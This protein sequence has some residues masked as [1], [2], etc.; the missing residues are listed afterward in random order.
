MWIR[1]H[2]ANGTQETSEPALARSLRA[3]VR[4]LAH[5]R[6]F[7]AEAAQNRKIGDAIADE[8]G[9]LGF[10]VELQGRY[11]NVV[12]LPS[13]AERQPCT[14]VCAHYDS[15]PGCPGADD[16]A[17]GVAVLLECA[18]RVAELRVGGLGFVAFNAEE[19][20]LLG[21]RDFV[22]SGLSALSLKLKMVHVLEMCGYRSMGKG[23][24]LGPLPPRLLGLD[25]G[26][27]IAMIGR[28]AS[29][30]AVRSALDATMVPN[31][32]RIGV[33]TTEL[34]TRLLPDIARSD[35]YPFW[36][37]ELPAVLWTDTGNFRNPNYHQRSDTPETL[38]YRFMADVTELLCRVMQH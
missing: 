11:R 35:H 5:P 36:N 8:L 34:A 20:G 24:Q 31:L 18:R 6:H 38:D 15:V 3:W 12:A 30:C 33:Q 29:N 10:R 22:E 9:R 23:S 17:S 25:A 2:K 26:T 28:G 14:L 21:S 16:N 1:E 27:F 32:H 7:W 37:A 19:D 13:G 4:T